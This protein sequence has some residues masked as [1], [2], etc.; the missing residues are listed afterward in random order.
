[1]LVMKSG[2]PHRTDRMELANQYKFRPLAE[3]E[4][5]E[6]LG[7][8]ESDTIKKVEMKDKIQ[9]ESLRKTKNL[10]ETK[11]SRKN[12]LKEMNKYLGCAPC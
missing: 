6:Y 10:L 11:L 12:L 8:L 3:N 9:K 5:Y 1:M 7:T 4:T 2:K